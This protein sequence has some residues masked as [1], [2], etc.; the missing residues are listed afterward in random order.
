MKKLFG[1]LAVAMLGGI[2][3]LGGYKLFFT[4]TVIIK[5]QLPPKIENINTNFNPAFNKTA[6]TNDNYASIDFTEAAEK[7]LNS[8]VH[9]KNTAIRTQVNP[10][11]FFFGN[12]NGR[13]QYEAVGT[14]SGVIIS[15]DGYIVT[16][17]HVIANAND[18]D[19]SELEAATEDWD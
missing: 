2:L 8:V 11:D 1:L 19:T 13:R 9:V 10:L 4:D 5:E 14:G 17:N 6:V 16:N 18:I 7:S 15:S 12:G 3:T